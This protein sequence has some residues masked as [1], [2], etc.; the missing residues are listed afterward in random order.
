MKHLIHWALGLLVLTTAVSLSGA[1]PAQQERPKQGQPPK[2]QK[3]GGGGGQQGRNQKANAA[4][5]RKNE[6]LKAITKI[7]PTLKT[8]L[9][10]SIALAEKESGGKA[11]EANL[12]M[13]A[14]KPVFKVGLM[15]ADHFSNATVDPETKTVTVT[16]DKAA[17]K[18]VEKKST[19]DDD[20]G[21]GE[22][23][24]ED[25]DG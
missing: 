16:A 18:G 25:E 12:D 6:K 17:A 1:W 2:V 14:G 21:G 7:L 15:V 19:G 5:Q 13:V 11:Y 3:A 20:E 10:E 8:S 24:D 23:E 9:G 4:L 22:V